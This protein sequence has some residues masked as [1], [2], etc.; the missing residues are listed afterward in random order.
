MI[1]AGA[2]RQT[3]PHKMRISIRKERKLDGLFLER[4]KSSHTQN[5]DG[6]V[7]ANHHP[8]TT[9]GITHAQKSKKL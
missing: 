2:K 3:E 1:W 9:K 8:E 5:A 6:T 4:S 7:F